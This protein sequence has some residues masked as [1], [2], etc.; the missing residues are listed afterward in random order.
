MAKQIVI[1]KIVPKTIW[2]NKLLN[3]ATTTSGLINALKNVDVLDCV[4]VYCRCDPNK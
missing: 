3:I 2:K 1:Q 4:A